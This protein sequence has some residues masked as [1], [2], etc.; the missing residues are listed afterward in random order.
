MKKRDLER[1]I[2]ERLE[3][4]F[5]NEEIVFKHKFAGMYQTWAEVEGAPRVKQC[6]PM[7]YFAPACCAPKSIESLANDVAI[8]VGC[9]ATTKDAVKGKVQVSRGVA[10]GTV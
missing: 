9:N 10:D 5:P 7:Y 4:E 2:R 6:L 8:S 1:A 3:R